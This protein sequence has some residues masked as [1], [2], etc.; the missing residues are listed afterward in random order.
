VTS[1]EIEGVVLE[2]MMPGE[3]KRPDDCSCTILQ[4]R[5]RDDGHLKG[6]ACDAGRVIGPSPDLSRYE[7]PRGYTKDYKARMV[8]NVAA[9]VLLFALVSIAAF[10]F[11]GLEQIQHCASAGSCG[12]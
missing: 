12:Y 11:V 5:S 8:E 9:V 1:E 2:P 4:F 10:S 3:P 6:D 7:N